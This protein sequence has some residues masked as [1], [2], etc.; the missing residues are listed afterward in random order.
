M[1]VP[2]CICF[3]CRSRQAARFQEALLPYVIV[4]K[5][6]GGRGERGLGLRMKSDS[7]DLR[8]KTA[9]GAGRSSPL[10]SYAW[11]REPKV[12]T[13]RSPVLV[14]RNIAKRRL[15][16]LER[17]TRGLPRKT[18]RFTGCAIAAR[19]SGTRA[20]HSSSNEGVSDWRRSRRVMPTGSKQSWRIA[21][22][23]SSRTAK[24]RAPVS[25]V[26]CD[27]GV[28]GSVDCE[29]CRGFGEIRPHTRIR[30]AEAIHAS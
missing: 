5:N 3:V 22:N 10:R 9:Q 6:D 12:T 2:V 20:A 14:M 24:M 4:R 15:G 8:R 18:R 17:G 30:S 16:K 1:D 19:E 29:S 28:R 7:R 13:G 11:R 23:R 27:R 25:R 26:V 21:P